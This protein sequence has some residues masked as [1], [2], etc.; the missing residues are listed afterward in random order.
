MGFIRIP[1]LPGRFYV[2]EP[3]AAASKKHPCPDCQCCQ[4]CAD[5]RCRVCRREASG[6]CLGAVAA[7]AGPDRLTLTRSSAPTNGTGAG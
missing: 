3:Q 5:E 7:A 4:W 1:G 6:P 2:P